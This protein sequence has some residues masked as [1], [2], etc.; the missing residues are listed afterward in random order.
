MIGPYSVHQMDDFYSAL[1]RGEV[2]PTGIMNYLQ[3]LLITQRCRSGDRVAD[4]CCGRGLQLP[5]L[6]R[7]R[8]DLGS[9]CGLD[10]S[11]A[12]IAQ[13][14]Q[15]QA[16][17]DSI[18]EPAFP[19]TFH[20]CDVAAPWPVTGL[21]DRVVYTSA[22]EHL[23]REHGVA[24]LRHLAA[25]LAPLGRLY[26]STPNTP[27]EPPRPLQHRVHVYEWS[28]HELVDELD[29]VGLVVEE[30]VGILAPP[31]TVGAEDT[32]QVEMAVAA[33]YGEAAAGFYAAMR[34]FTPAALLGPVV[35]TALAEDAS[36][37]LYVCS[38]RP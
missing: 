23:P 25:A 19:I 7:Y 5:V 28:H 34:Q 35:S 6:Y 17:L 27:G 36:E 3:R 1:G 18:Y 29:H 12:N 8:P 26:L 16:E 14:M 21:F 4:V 9:Y 10:I 32:D 37:I 13:A 15:R 31:A 22:L 30:V 33:R 20:V 24:S 38:R 2:K 11:A